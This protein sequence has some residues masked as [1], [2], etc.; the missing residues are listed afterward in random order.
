M[1]TCAAETYIKCFS[2]FT[3]FDSSDIQVRGGEQ[4][5]ALNTLVEFTCLLGV[6]SS[7]F[8]F[9]FHHL[10]LSDFSEVIK[11]HLCLVVMVVQHCECTYFY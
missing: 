2:I 3:S 10:M 6:M 7:G 8:R 9:P 11:N 5:E 4:M 1:V